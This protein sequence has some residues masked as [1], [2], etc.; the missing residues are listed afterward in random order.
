MGV[1]AVASQ[2]VLRGRG[3]E[4]AALDRVL[5]TAQGDSSAVLVLRGAPGIGKT[6]LLDYAAGRADGFRTVAVAGIESEMELP[7]AGLHQLCAPLLGRLGELPAPQRNALSVAFGL[8][9][10]G[11]PQRF[12]VGLAVLSLL[13]GAAVDQPVACLVDDAQWL[14]DGS[15]QALAFVARRLV[16]EPVALIFARRDSAG[17]RELA[18]LPELIVKG[19]RAPEARALLASAVRVPFDPLVR[20][21]IVAEAHGNP[22]ALLQLPRALTPAELAGGFGLPRGGPVADC[23]E[24]V[25]HQRFQTLP[26]ES[27]RLLMTGAAEPTGDVAL[28]WRAAG[29]QG[30][31]GDAATA[32]EAA[33]LIEFGSRARFHHPLVRSAVYQ[34]MSAPQRR[35][36][37]QALAEATDPHLDPDRKAWHRAHAAARPEESVA[38]DLERSACRAQSRGGVVAAAAF[39]RRAAELTPDPARRITRAL[40]AAQATIDAGGV[41]QAHCILAAAEAGPLDDLQRARLERLRARLVF[42]EVRSGDAPRRLLDAAHRLAPL[43]AAL[44]RDTLLEATGAAISAGRLSEGPGLREVAEA[45]RAGPPPSAPPRMVDVLL[46]SLAD[47]IIDGNAAGVDA[48]KHALHVVQQEQRSGASDADKRWLWL[49]FRVT[50]EPLA[51]ELW[52]DEAWYELAAGAVAVSREAG[53]LAILPMALTYQACSHVHAGEFDTAAALIDEATAI[54]DAAGGVPMMYTSLVLGAWRGQESQ[55]LG[56]IEATIK[57][58]RARGEGRA[59]AL[60]E[61]ATALLHNGLG[62]YDVAL[63]AATRACQYEDLG[64]FGWALI[65][66]I[67]AAVRSGQPEVAAAAL[68]KLTERTGASGTD[69]A[70]GAEACSRAL[71]SDDQAA[72]ALYQEAIERLG[73]GRIT[74][75]LARAHL[76]YGEWLRRRNRRQDSR[77]QLR[78]AYETFSRIGAEGFAERARRE[79]LATGETVRKRTVDT[80]ARLTSQEAQIAGLAREGKTNGEIAAQLFISSRTVEWHLGN[81]FT[82]LGVSSRRQLRSV[83]SP[84]NRRH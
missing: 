75:S 17:D 14:D 27:R 80:L 32:A 45:V 19:L 84:P 47:L 43:D 44:A 70:L 81:V 29:L 61:Y 18:G 26:E 22:M 2:V 46:D 31:S 33:G 53:A 59:L 13:A 37:H 60:A 63:A 28:L 23:I 56:L 8:R 57:E 67:E 30:I 34:G 24:I 54:S 58:V 39:L 64:I 36:A 5:A 20:E 52:D 78:T 12:L 72:D 74:V 73:R 35:A 65:E 83:L 79:L 71:L 16:A 55:A 51:P 66:L 4:M 15:L 68:G 7:Y 1:H 11:P 25:L 77:T 50:P 41:D 62:H 49:A 3:Q 21:R 48:L 38:F 42:S 9:E 69:W 10:G 76:L 6:A 82:K 40:A